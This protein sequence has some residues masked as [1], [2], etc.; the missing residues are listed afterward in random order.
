MN[1]PGWELLSCEKWGTVQELPNA[2][3]LLLSLSW[4]L[5]R[6]PEGF[7]IPQVKVCLSG[8]IGWLT[9]WPPEVENQPPA[10]LALLHHR[11]HAG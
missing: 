8:N 7:A 10:P 9:E 5:A 11:V 6:F 1:N 4:K 2:F 3:S